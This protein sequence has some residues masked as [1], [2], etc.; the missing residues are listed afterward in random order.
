MLRNVRSHRSLFIPICAGIVVL[1]LA[2]G[3]LTWHFL[4]QPP[5]PP[6]ATCGDVV[7]LQGRLRQPLN[8]DA[9]QVELCFYHAYQQC[10]AVTINVGEHGTDTGDSTT[11]WPAKQGNTCRIIAQYSTFGLVSSA[12]LTETGT[13]Q[14]VVHKNGGLL[15]LQCGTSGDVFVAG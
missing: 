11:Y 13:C 5:T 9:P 10:A 2:A 7:F 14:G 6:Q 15:L 12:N 1:L 8:K 3:L 4:S